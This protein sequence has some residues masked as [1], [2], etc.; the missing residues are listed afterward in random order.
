MSWSAR[1]LPSLRLLRRKTRVCWSRGVSFGI[2]NGPVDSHP[3]SPAVAAPGECFSG[4]RLDVDD[5]LTFTRGLVDQDIPKDTVSRDGLWMILE[6]NAIHVKPAFLDL[7]FVFRKRM[8]D[9]PDQEND[10]F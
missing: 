8:R 6:G 10:G 3:S 5:H 4:R 7:A 2:L 9:S 1:D